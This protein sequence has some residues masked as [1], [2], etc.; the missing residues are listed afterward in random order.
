[1]F[2]RRPSTLIRLEMVEHSLRAWVWRVAQI[3]VLPI[4]HDRDR[5]RHDR[6][7]VTGLRACNLCCLKVTPFWSLSLRRG[8]WPFAEAGRD[9]IAHHWGS[10][11]YAGPIIA[12]AEIMEHAH[13]F[14]RWAL[15]CA[16][17]FAIVPR[18]RRHFRK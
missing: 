11:R 16:D 1:M 10:P 7:A 4:P 14:S 2:D 12:A 15:W 17:A 13:R 3:G 9:E 5:C 8:P 6:G 18:D